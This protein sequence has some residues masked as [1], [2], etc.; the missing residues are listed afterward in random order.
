MTT[1]FVSPAN[2]FLTQTYVDYIKSGVVQQSYPE[3]DTAACHSNI[4]DNNTASSQV[5]EQ[6][7]FRVP[8]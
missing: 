8:L 3:I 1:N 7:G 6:K 5:I 4:E 2:V